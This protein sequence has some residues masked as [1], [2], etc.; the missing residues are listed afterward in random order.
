MSFSY[1]GDPKTSE[2]DYMR[3]MIGDTSEQGAILTNEEINWMVIEYPTLSTRIAKAYR[4][5]ATS[6]A[7]IPNR[8]LGPQ[9]ENSTNRVKYFQQQAEFYE[10]MSI[11]AGGTPPLP[12]YSTEKV[13]DKGMMANAE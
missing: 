3:F 8:R 10:R 11:L 7:K 1:S 6:F 13:F 12:E 2:L 5:M 9:E 4:Q